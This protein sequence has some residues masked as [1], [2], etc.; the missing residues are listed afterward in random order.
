[1]ANAGAFV[2]HAKPRILEDL[3]VVPVLGLNATEEQMEACNAAALTASQY[4]SNAISG[5]GTSHENTEGGEFE[6]TEGSHSFG[7]IDDTGGIFAPMIVRDQA[8]GNQM[9][10]ADEDGQLTR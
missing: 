4:I 5:S 7:A 8:H 2:D 3:Q 9:S 10:G 6:N 1:M